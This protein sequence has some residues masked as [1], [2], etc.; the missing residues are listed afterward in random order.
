MKVILLQNIKKIGKKFEI[1]EVASG[2]AQ[3][4]LIPKKLAIPATS[5]AIKKLEQQISSAA[6]SDEMMKNDVIKKLESLNGKK[7]TV[8]AK[9]NDKGVLYAKFHISEIIES[10]EKLHKIVLEA[11][12]IKLDEPLTAL[13]EHTIQ[14]EA[15]DKKFKFTLEITAE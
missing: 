7:V 4:N 15:F 11:T 9:A 14:L 12:Y 2:Y 5:E 8:T 10:I 3:N 1:K 6:K 13:G